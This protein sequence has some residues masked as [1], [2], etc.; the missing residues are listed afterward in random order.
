L[1]LKLIYIAGNEPFNQG[2]I[3]YKKVCE[4]ASAKGIFVNTI[5]CYFILMSLI[6]SFEKFNA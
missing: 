1:D 4:I 5:Y 6:N 2:P 3:D